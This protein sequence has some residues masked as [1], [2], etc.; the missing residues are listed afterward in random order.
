DAMAEV[1]KARG[2]LEA[3]GGN[4]DLRERVRQWLT[5]LDTAAKLEEIRLEVYDLEDRDKGYA[6]DARVFREY[7]IDVEALPAEDVTARVTASRIKR[8]LVL[9]LRNG[10][11]RLR[12]KP[13]PRD[14][15]RRQRLVAIV[16]AAD[17]DPWEQRL[18]AAFEAKDV[19]TLRKLANG[20]D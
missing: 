17:P 3:G 20:T 10:A 4:D 1:Q 8:D 18:Q 12:Y 15:V 14:P 5:D 11:G 7:G 9:A 2:L 6:D 19:R 16:R 13:R